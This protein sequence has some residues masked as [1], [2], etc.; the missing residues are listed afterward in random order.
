MISPQGSES[1]S[2]SE[3]DSE[4]SD[5]HKSIF[6]KPTRIHFTILMLKL[7]NEE[8]VQAASNVLQVRVGVLSE[9]YL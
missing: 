9:N 4:S 6:L 1:S 7:W 2:G 3:E 8:R 5:I